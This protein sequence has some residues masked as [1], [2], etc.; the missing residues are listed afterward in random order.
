MPSTSSANFPDFRSDL[1]GSR[2][3]RVILV[4]DVVESVRWMEIDEARAISRWRKFSKH[5]RDQVTVSHQGRVVKSLG[6]GLM[7][8]FSSTP[9]AARAAAAIH[10]AAAQEVRDGGRDAPIQLRVGI[11]QAEATKDE[12]DLY[13]RGVNL[14]AR[15]ATLAG[16]GETVVSDVCRDHL[17]DWVDSD[18]E[19]LGD[20]YL[21]HIAE[22]VRVYRVGPAGFKPILQSRQDY[23]PTLVPTISFIPFE[24]RN[25][26]A[27]VVAVG[28]LIADGVIAQ[29]SRTVGLRVISRLSSGGLRGRNLGKEALSAGLGAD[30]VANGSYLTAGSRLMVSAE[31]MD[32]RTGE[33]CWSDRLNTEIEDLL[34]IESQCCHR[35]ADGIHGAVVNQQAQKAL[36]KPLPT[37]ESYSLL[38]GSINLMHRSSTREFQRSRDALDMLVER[39][40]RSALIRA[41]L[42][43]WHVLN[44]VRGISGDTKR[45]T[46]LALDEAHR[47]QDLEP[48][49]AYAAA[50]HGHALCHLSED[51]ESSL[52]HLDKA[53]ELNPSESI[54]WL[55]KSVWSSMWGSELDAVVEAE[56]AKALSPL[57]PM[58]Y[59]YD[60]VL[61]GAY[62]FAGQH[63]KAILAGVASLRKNR[64][65]APTLRALLIAQFESGREADARQTL[66][67]LLQETP[68]LTVSGYLS[69]GGK[70]SRSR[71]RVAHAFRQLGLREY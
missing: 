18:I 44:V 56:K 11:H 48:S 60:M 35:L 31:L 17:T 64:H 21:K 67:L 5:I 47:A 36:T 54:A 58:G 39:H 46:K 34:N 22:P 65:H 16:P 8:E 63:D 28:D 62:A 38:L 61:T 27:E 15:I 2:S 59:Y 3:N 33:I 10:Q 52:L 9:N 13:G 55:Y 43:K 49:N 53:I 42:G 37:L 24:S 29:L 41:W 45:D 7:L 69:M 6:D 4:C 66:H 51:P 12:F 30:Y 1:L 23:A 50:I 26:A 32:T 68:D 57:D 20:C 19:D 71:R 40:G 25:L 14:A 70:Q